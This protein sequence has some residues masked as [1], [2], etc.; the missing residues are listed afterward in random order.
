[1]KGNVVVNGGA[2]PKVLAPKTALVT[3]ACALVSGATG[4]L[5]SRLAATLAQ[6]GYRVRALARSTSDLSRLSNLGIEIVVG[7]IGDPASLARA[8]AGQ[9][10]VFHTAGKVTDWGQHAEFMTVNRDGTANV[11]AACQAAG[12]AHLV[13]VSSLTVLGLPRDGRLIDE[14]SPYAVAPPDSYTQSK[15]AAEQLVRAAHG[16]R[17]LTTTVIRPGVIWGA[18]DITI[19]PRIVTLMR[20]GRMP[21]LGRGDNLLALSHVDNLALGCKL[22]VE[23]AAAAGQIYHVTDG[24]PITLRQALDAIADVYHV[25]RPRSSMPVWAVQAA[26]ALIELAACLR[27]RSQPP[28]ITRFGV[29][30]LA[31]HCRYDIGKARRELSYAPRV[32]FAEGIAAMEGV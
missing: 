6:Q 10:V 9:R 20:R 23:N 18:G 30:M 28:A 3:G 12:V 26:A 31:S 15:I 2:L 4:F 22:A 17:G 19:V 14:Q 21:C 13:H 29:R 24:E 25:A 7:D 8:T 11:V 32:S 16:Q 27:G 5:G 1:M